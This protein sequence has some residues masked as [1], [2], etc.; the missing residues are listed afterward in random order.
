[1]AF[2]SSTMSIAE[3][4]LLTALLF[5]DT[6]ET[7]FWRLTNYRLFACEDEKS[8]FDKRKHRRFGLDIVWDA[9]AEQGIYRSTVVER[10]NRL[11][12]EPSSVEQNRLCSQYLL[13][14]GKCGY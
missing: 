7:A 10:V 3:R 5:G 8:S 14:L 9:M 2:E 12:H 6:Y 1:M 11:A 4:C 13:M